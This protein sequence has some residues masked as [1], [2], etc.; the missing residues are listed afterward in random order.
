MLP[1]LVPML[2]AERVLDI[3]DGHAARLA[4]TSAA[5]IGRQLAG[6][7]RR[8]CRMAVPTPSPDPC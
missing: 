8:F 4:S 1:E 6:H 5:T 2:R 7:G 3:T